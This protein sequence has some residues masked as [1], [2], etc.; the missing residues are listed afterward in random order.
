MK[1]KLYKYLYFKNTLFMLA[2]YLKI[3]NKYLLVLKD[4]LDGLD[5]WVWIGKFWPLITGFNFSP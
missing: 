1:E 5:E 3:S 4:F 2:V